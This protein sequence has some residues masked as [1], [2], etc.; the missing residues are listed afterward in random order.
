MSTGV[1]AFRGSS[2]VEV[3]A[4]VIGR[5]ADFTALPRWTPRVVR[6][7]IRRCL[8][9]DPGLRGSDIGSIRREIDHARQRTLY[10]QHTVIATAAATVLIVLM[11]WT[12]A[13]LMRPAIGSARITASSAP[14]IAAF[15]ALKPEQLIASKGFDG[16][17]TYAPD[18]KSVAYSSDRSGAMPIYVQGTS[19][20]STAVQLTEEG[21]NIQ[22]VWSPDA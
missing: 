6:S 12:A 5:E 4:T 1:R 7:M 14:D 21:Q 15:A 19:P 2:A 11:T 10:G 3:L 18:G 20:G 9:K 22:P 8:Q 16:F 13:Q 17:L